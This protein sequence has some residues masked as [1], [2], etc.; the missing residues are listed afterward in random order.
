MN[1]APCLAIDLPGCG[2]SSF[3]PTSWDAY[4]VDALVELLAVIIEDYREK[5]AGQGLVLIGHSMG[6]SLAALLAS[7][8]S[9]QR[10]MLTDL[11]WGW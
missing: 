10:I 1:L 4:K 5:T 9:G 2:L 3:D 7:R 11:S 6:C 8:T